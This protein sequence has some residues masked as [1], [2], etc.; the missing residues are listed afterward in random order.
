MDF[1]MLQGSLA[2]YELGIAVKSGIYASS[3]FGGDAGI[4]S[5]KGLR[6]IDRKTGK[7]Y[8]GLL[9]LPPARS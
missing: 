2:V 1:P 6:V 7:D 9:S 3:D 4:N 5:T 8:A